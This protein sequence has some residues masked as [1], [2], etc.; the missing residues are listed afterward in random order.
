[1][2][3]TLDLIGSLKSSG[4][5]AIGGRGGQGLME[6]AGNILPSVVSGAVEGMREWRLATEAQERA[7]A[8][9]RGVALPE[10]SLNPQP[11]QVLPAAPPAPAPATATTR[12]QEETMGAPPLD[13]VLMK[14]VEIMKDLSL[15]VDEQVDEV[16]AWLYRAMPEL[17]AQILDPPKIDPRL[18]PGEQ[19]VLQLFQNQPVLT[20]VPVNPRLTEFIKKFIVAAKEA[21]AERVASVEKQTPPTKAS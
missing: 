3:Q 20:Q 16:L 7:L 9:Q 19:G 11:A 2:Q 21:E 12:T 17:V 6:I 10:R 4:L 18:A 1:V 15:T 13:W 8:I 14:V 5:F